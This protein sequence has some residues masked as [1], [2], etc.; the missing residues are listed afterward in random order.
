MFFFKLNIKN[1]FQLQEQ[2]AIVVYWRKENDE[3]TIQMWLL[4]STNGKYAHARLTCTRRFNF[5]G[6]RKSCMSHFLDFNERKK[7]SKTSKTGNNCTVLHTHIAVFD[8]SEAKQKDWWL[9]STRFPALVT[10]V[11][12]PALGAGCTLT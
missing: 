6:C 1:N 4:R 11:C 2:R 5:Q 12:F 10:A 9:S 3:R 7:I 8:R